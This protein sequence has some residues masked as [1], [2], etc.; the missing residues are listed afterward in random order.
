MLLKQACVVLVYLFVTPSWCTVNDTLVGYLQV[1]IVL[2]SDFE[3]ANLTLCKLLLCSTGFHV[4]VYCPA[5][6]RDP[7][8]HSIAPKSHCYFTN[9]VNVYAELLETFIC[10]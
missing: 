6:L 3:D 10:Y 1:I 7:A 9:R 5:L 4:Q 2:L 8:C